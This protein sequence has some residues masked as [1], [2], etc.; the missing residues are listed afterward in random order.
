MNG[1]PPPPCELDR[2]TGEGMGAGARVGEA[3]RERACVVR[4]RDMPVLRSAGAR[5]WCGWVVGER[6]S[7][8]R[9]WREAVGVVMLRF[10]TARDRGNDSAAAGAVASG[11]RTVEEVYGV[12]VFSRFGSEDGGDPVRRR[13]TQS[14]LN[15]KLRRPH[16]RMASARLGGM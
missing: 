16:S 8:G 15:P 2:R 9:L 10:G 5:W 1:P 14:P 13:E 3:A 4:E 6:K 11:V 7:E 12:G